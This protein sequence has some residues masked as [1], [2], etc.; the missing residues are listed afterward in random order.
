M[1][2]LATLLL[3]GAALAAP[4]SSSLSGPSGNLSWQVSEVGGTVT[5][6]GSSPKWKIE[7][8]ADAALRPRSTR[9]TNPDGAVTTAVWE[10]DTVTVVMPDGKVVVHNEAGIWD[11]DSLDVRLGERVRKKLPGDHSF[12]A[13][14]T[15]SGKVYRF[16]AVDKGTETCATGP[17]QKINVTLAGWMKLVGPSVD[18]WFADDGRLVKFDGPSG[19]FAAK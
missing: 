14:D 13:L 17:C 9:R 7:H 15:G 4:P 18:F 19:E 8:T 10:G 5:L 16:D 1:I 11:G 12:K 6:V 2:W 3:G